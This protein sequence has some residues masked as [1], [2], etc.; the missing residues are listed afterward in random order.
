MTYHNLRSDSAEHEPTKRYEI[1]IAPSVRNLPP[2]RCGRM[3]D[4]NDDGTAVVDLDVG[5]TTDPP[6]DWVIDKPCE[7]AQAITAMSSPPDYS[8]SGAS[9][10][11][12]MKRALA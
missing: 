9:S 12:A 5:V 11:I 10:R 1:D 8:T 6:E 2:Y 7:A 3:N 4:L